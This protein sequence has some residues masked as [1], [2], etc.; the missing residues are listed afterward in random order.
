MHRMPGIEMDR[1][2]SAAL[3]SVD[4]TCV[5][6]ML[7][8]CGPIARYTNRAPV[9]STPYGVDIACALFKTEGGSLGTRG[10]LEF[11]DGL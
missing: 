11:H 9:R 7:T 6:P 5:D 8:T 10:R 4:D 1:A 2:S 3:G